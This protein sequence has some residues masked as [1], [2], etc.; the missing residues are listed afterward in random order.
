L[1]DSILIPV[2]NAFTGDVYVTTPCMRM[3]SSKP[4]T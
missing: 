1:L 4:T 3:R 2:A